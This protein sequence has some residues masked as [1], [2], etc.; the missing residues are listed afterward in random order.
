MAFV[1]TFTFHE[2]SLKVQ[3]GCKK[4]HKMQ[5][6]EKKFLK[7]WGGGSVEKMLRP[8]WNASGTEAQHLDTKP[9]E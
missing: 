5:N 6:W 1:G 3:F 4:N 8:E 9:V 2:E 7:K